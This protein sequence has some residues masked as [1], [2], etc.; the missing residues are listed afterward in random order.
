MV[1]S[2]SGRFR[3]SITIGAIA[4]T[5][6]STTGVSQ[7]AAPRFEAPITTNRSIAVGATPGTKSWTVSIARTAALVIGR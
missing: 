7:V 1:L 6:G 3:T 5:R 2:C 4:T